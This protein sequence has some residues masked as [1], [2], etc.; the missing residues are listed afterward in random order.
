MTISDARARHR[1]QQLVLA[2]IARGRQT[3]RL[4][5]LFDQFSA[6]GTFFLPGWMAERYAQG[7]A[8]RDS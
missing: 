6:K 7:P 3:K 1:A 8:A 2:R 4:L 5:D